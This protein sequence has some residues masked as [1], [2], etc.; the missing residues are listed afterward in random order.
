MA[1]KV[2]GCN[3]FGWS[4]DEHCDPAV[5]ADPRPG[6]TAGSSNFQVTLPLTSGTL[7]PPRYAPTPRRDVT[8][9]AF[10]E[11]DRPT[12]PPARTGGTSRPPPG[13]RRAPRTRTNDAEGTQGSPPRAA[14][15]SPGSPGP[16][17][18]FPGQRRHLA[19]RAR[20]GPPSPRPTPRSRRDDPHA[21]R[22]GA[23]AVRPAGTAPTGTSLSRHRAPDHSPPPG[24]V[25]RLRAALAE[26]HPL[27]TGEH[28]VDR[29]E[30]APGRDAVAEAPRA[31]TR[32]QRPGPPDPRPD[33]AGRSTI[34]VVSP[35]A[36]VDSAW[37]TALA[38][39]SGRR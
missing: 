24:E 5:L 38:T 27:G 2:R 26:V 23:G 21:G 33:Q 30:P 14:G 22:H 29:G 19:V 36:G 34:S 39:V 3:T 7:P 20:A 37:P 35:S 31:T 18:G 1:H 16:A 12:P 25:A 11:A 10:V 17:P 6:S 32:P 8:S 9:T 4:Y 28:D 15:T 13:R